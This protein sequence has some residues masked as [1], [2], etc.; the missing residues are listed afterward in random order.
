M[1][2]ILAAAAV[3]VL[4]AA[5]ELGRVLTVLAK[6]LKIVKIAG[7]FSHTNTPSKIT[8]PPHVMPAKTKRNVFSGLRG[9]EDINSLHHKST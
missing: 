9:R 4:E 6:L 3:L 8:M 1:S 2:A 7:S 5:D